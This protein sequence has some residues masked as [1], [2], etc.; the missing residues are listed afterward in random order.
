MQKLKKH[1]SELNRTMYELQVYNG[2]IFTTKTVQKTIRKLSE[3]EN[4]IS[5][6]F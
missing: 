4:G 1:L 5:V 3:S 2:S 6:F